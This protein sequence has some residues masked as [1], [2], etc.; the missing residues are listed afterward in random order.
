MHLIR[1]RLKIIIHTGFWVFFLVL[2]FFFYSNFW[3]IPIAVIRAVINGM[4][5]I[6]LFYIN[7]HILIPWLFRPG[8]YYV[9]GMASVLLIAVFIPV[10]IAMREYWFGEPTGIVIQGRPYVSEFLI[11]TSLFF[12]YMT[13][14]FYKLIES[15]LEARERTREIARQRDEAEL[16]M[17]K[18]QVNPHFLFNTL[19]NLYTLAYT[20]SEKTGG[21]ILALSEIMRYLI[22]ETSAVLVPAEKEVRFISNYISLEKLRIEDAGKVSFSVEQPGPGLLVSPLLFIAFVENAFKHSGI[23]S[24]PEGF[25]QVFLSFRESEILFTC[26]N[27]ILAGQ[28]PREK[29]GVGLTNTRARLELIYPGRHRLEI[30][31]TNLVYAV[32]LTIVP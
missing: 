18:S 28:K 32:S 20:R 30:R 31:Q 6:S 1:G 8:K 23:D 25:I 13:S 15:Q 22:Y 27:S 14:V 5:F 17:L 21:A 4:I 3:P 19:N 12:V 29:G 7:L 11:V 9:Y 2:S 26:E 24:D 16:R 10:R